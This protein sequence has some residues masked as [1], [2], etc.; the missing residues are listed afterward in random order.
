MR[1]V[2]VSIAAVV[3][4]DNQPNNFIVVLKEEG[5]NRRL[6]V[7]IGSAEAQAIALP[8]QNIRPTRPLTHD[9]FRET[10]DSLGVRVKEVVISDLKNGTFFAVLVL[11][12]AD[13]SNLELDSRPSDAMAA[14]VR[15]ESPIYVY[16]SILD[17]AGMTIELGENPP[18]PVVAPQEPLAP[19][20]R[21]STEK[22]E[23]M[24][25]E[26]LEKEDYERAAKIRDE[27]IRRQNN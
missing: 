6:P 27:M 12:K 21:Y 3:R 24:L 13:G 26:A 23:Q 18:A 8:L 1:K 17:E 10:L 14:A 7:V 2:Q 25:D 5:G 15:F 4:N 9:L 22:L 11:T 19:L 16:E 20:D